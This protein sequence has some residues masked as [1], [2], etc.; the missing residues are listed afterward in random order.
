MILTNI[1]GTVKW[2]NVKNGY[3][4]I[5]RDDT[6]EDVFVHQTAITRNNPRKYLRS[7]GDG[8]KVQFDIVAGD[9]G[10]EAANVTGPGGQPVQGSKYAADRRDGTHPDQMLMTAMTQRLWYGG[11]MMLPAPSRRPRNDDRQYWRQVEIDSAR[12][13]RWE[14]APRRGYLPDRG[15]STNSWRQAGP[16]RGSRSEHAADSGYV[17]RRGIRGRSGAAVDSTSQASKGPVNEKTT[18]V[19]VS[20]ISANGSSKGDA[21][22]DEPEPVSLTGRYRR[23]ARVPRRGRLTDKNDDDAE[24]ALVSRLTPSWSKYFL[25]R[26]SMLSALNAIANPSVRPSRGVASSK[27]VGWTHIYGERVE[28]EPITGVWVQG[29]S[30]WSGGQGGEVPLKLKTF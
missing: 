8:E 23:R 28:R 2:F 14:S 10:T 16:P 5:N 6:K 12:Y 24:N 27:N 25:A 22:S 7:V 19:N 1:I 11:P 3:G 29:Q 18:V 17:E 26:D 13:G 9:K 21:G 15:F 30:P 4:F 20:P